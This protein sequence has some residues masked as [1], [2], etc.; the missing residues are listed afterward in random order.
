MQVQPERGCRFSGPALRY[1]QPVGQQALIQE[2]RPDPIVIVSVVWEERGR[3]ASP[4][5]D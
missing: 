2:T 3:K 5:P 1:G 4:Y